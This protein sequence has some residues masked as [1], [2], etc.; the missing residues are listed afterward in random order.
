MRE[1]VGREGNG[2]DG[3]PAADAVRQ[4][5]AR[6]HLLRL[7][8]RVLMNLLVQTRRESE[9][10]V[11][12]LERRNRRLSEANAARARHA[13]RQRTGVAPEGAGRT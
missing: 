4:L 3:D 9:A 6:L 1:E 12:A 13:W 10:R 11:R 5:E 7:S 2:L 8:R